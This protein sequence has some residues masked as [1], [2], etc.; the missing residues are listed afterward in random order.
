MAEERSFL[1]QGWSFPPVFNRKNKK[2]EM[3]KEEE[4]IKQSLQ[5]LL[6]TRIG[7][8]VMRP[9]FGCN[10]DEMLFENLDI[11]L[12]TYVTDLIESAILYFEPRIELNAVEIQPDN[13][14]E[15]LLMIHLIY[16]IR[17]TNTRNNFVYPFY[18]IE[19]TNF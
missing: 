8:R 6:S 13:E 15:G 9:D 14:L 19:G 10:L 17:S 12:K 11:T 16:T 5:I 1:G 4:D 2:V 18:K 7:E 3:V